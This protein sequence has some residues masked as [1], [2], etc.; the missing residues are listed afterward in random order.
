MTQVLQHRVTTAS[1]GYKGT[2][3]YKFD[4]NSKIK[5]L[6]RVADI[7]LNMTLGNNEENSAVTERNTEPVG[8]TPIDKV[9]IY[10]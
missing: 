9:D 4:E 6:I 10:Q 1:S 7:C 8:V 3:L 2:E 5:W